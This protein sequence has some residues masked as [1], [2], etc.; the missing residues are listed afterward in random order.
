MTVGGATVFFLQAQT[1]VPDGGNVVTGS[2]TDYYWNNTNT[3]ID[4]TGIV[5][6]NSG[7]GNGYAVYGVVAGE[8][9]KYFGGTTMAFQLVPILYQILALQPLKIF[10]VGE[11][12]STL[13]FML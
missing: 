8:T 4:V 12:V 3:D 13:R 7:D 11:R 9:W 10:R 1:A 5:L 2:G 6:S